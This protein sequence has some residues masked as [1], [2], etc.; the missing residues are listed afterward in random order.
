[1]ELIL[2]LRFF[3]ALP[4]VHITSNGSTTPESVNQSRAAQPTTPRQT[5]DEPQAKIDAD[6]SDFL[7]VEDSEGEILDFHALRHTAASWLIQ[8]GADVKTVQTIM[9]HSDIKLTLD[10]YGH[11]FPGSEADAVKRLESVFHR[12]IA[13]AA[14]GTYDSI[15]LRIAQHSQRIPLPNLANSC[16]SPTR[17]LNQNESAKPNKKAAISDETPLF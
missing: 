6:A 2:W 1:M 13:A 7:R 17:P 11:L 14:T 16:E 3:D 12:P 9:R 15:A 8:S 5:I 10:R 4:R